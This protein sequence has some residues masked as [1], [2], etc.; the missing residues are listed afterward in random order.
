MFISEVLR[1]FRAVFGRQIA[2]IGAIENVKIV[3]KRSTTLIK[4]K[5]YKIYNAFSVYYT[6]IK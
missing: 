3:S 2:Q 6:S 4:L 1:V 5:A